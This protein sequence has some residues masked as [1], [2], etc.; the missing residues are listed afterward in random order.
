MKISH[1]VMRHPVVIAMITIALVAFGFYCLYLSNIE[2]IS[3]LSLSSIEVVT[4]YPG[5]S[6]E[7]VERDV[8][9]V[10]EDDFVTL[11]NFKSVNSTNQNSFSWITINFTDDVDPYD[12]LDEI[13]YRI[14]QLVDSL[15]ASIQ[16]KPM[17]LVGGSTMI[18]IFEF[19]VSGGEDTGR[20]TRYLN[21]EIIPRLTKIDGVGSVAIIG[22]D[23]LQVEVKLRLDDLQSKGISVLEVF[24]LLNYSN[25][26]LPLGAATYEGKNVT[27]NYEGGLRSLDDIGDL[28]VGMGS[29]NVV[30]K[31]RD[32][33][34]ISFAYPKQDSKIFAEGSPMIV[35]R[36]MKRLAGNTMDITREVRQVM[37]QI[38]S[39]TNGALECGIITDESRTVVNS[40]TTVMESGV[41]GLVMAIVIVFFFL[42]DPKATIAIG[43]SIPLSIL[44]TFTGMKVLGMSINLISTAG[45]VVAIGMIVDGSI[46]ML[47]QVFRNFK[48]RKLNAIEAINKGSDEVS[49]SILASVLTTVVVFVP[50]F[51]LKGIVGLIVK[52][53]AKTLVICLLA[54]LLVALVFVPFILR[55][56]FGKKHPKTRDNVWFNRGYLWVEKTYKR[57]LAWCLAN[58]R[59]VI[60]IPILFLLISL[61]LVSILGYSFIPSVDNGDFYAEFEFPVGY[62]GEM[63]EAKMKQAEA[64]IRR[65]VPEIENMAVYSGQSPNIGQVGAQAMRLG[66]AHIILPPADQRERKINQIILSLQKTLSEEM[67][68][69]VVKVKNGGFDYL[70][71]YL[72][73]G[74][75]YQVSLVGTDVNLLYKTAL[76]LENEMRSLPEVVTTTID[77]NFDSVNVMLDMSRRHLN[78]L[79]ISSYEAGIVSRILFSGLEAG[80]MTDAASGKR[81]DINLTSDA[82]D[83][84]ITEDL[85]SKLTIKTIGGDFVSFAGLGDYKVENTI[86]AIKH[87]NRMKS[88]SV[89]ASLVGDDTSGV[90]NAMNAY[91]KEHP[92]PDG[93]ETVG[94]GTMKL[95]TDSLGQMVS[96]LII[97]VFLVYMV[98]VIQ[99]ERFRQPFIIMMSIPFAVIGVITGLLSFGSN[100]NLIS[101]VAV[102]SLAGVV[103]NNAIILI[104]YMN[105]L[106]DRKRAAWLHKVDESVVDTPD[107]TVTHD[108]GFDKFIGT[109]KEIQMLR[110]SVTEGGSSRLRP[111]LMTTLTTM[112]G[113]FPMAMS[114]GAGAELYA[115]V[116]QA[117]FGGLL[118]S[119]LVTLF[120]IPVVYYA[121]EKKSIIRK[122]RRLG[123][124]D[125]EDV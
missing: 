40:L 49:S 58:R 5:A 74:G 41:L 16:G 47:E 65:E 22:G 92:L 76:D 38:E 123:G 116:G 30:V 82:S 120:L 45:I 107:S 48:N 71:A 21:D 90:N 119:T 109:D 69:C 80:K 93:V 103:V 46:V 68:D 9:K 55:L 63:T 81:Y 57:G 73:E 96:V 28:T 20:I 2:F 1:Y 61:M 39:E 59:F 115:P 106:R 84:P 101:V 60:L 88:V 13:R 44:F 89:S 53:F 33:A 11:P 99:F 66:Y 98:M 87:R 86:N 77:T 56:F 102:I 31:L 114:F 79:G 24:Q 37:R 10:L 67:V 91:L 29:D 4:V 117:I 25:A 17:A 32:V 26:Y 113:V 23:D 94:V 34:D 35:V 62:S 75:G 64:I 36:I 125:E 43:L 8:T 50:M 12:Q 112:F 85:L 52:D 27:F 51:T 121:M 108:D 97:G 6:A 18:P 111:I 95:I 118:T 78:S 14:D 19:S 42:F 110:E 15:P 124:D 7:E 104:D 70:L 122:A 100:L 54:S 72:S 3:D 105:L 83:Q